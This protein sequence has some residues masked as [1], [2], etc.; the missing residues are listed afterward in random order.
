ME[1]A[2]CYLV[3]SDLARASCVGRSWRSSSGVAWATLDRA[4]RRIQRVTRAALA[5][6]ETTLLR[7]DKFWRMLHSP[8]DED[9]PRI[10]WAAYHS[11]HVPAPG[12][13]WA[14]DK[15]RQNGMPAPADAVLNLR[16]GLLGAFAFHRRITIEQLQ[17]LGI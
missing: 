3:P 5:K 10:L 7:S 16:P 6:M 8:T 4:A 11:C 15:L 1:Y 13:Q 9:I 17:C 2:L 12:V 14:I